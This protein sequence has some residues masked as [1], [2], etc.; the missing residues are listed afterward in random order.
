[1]TAASARKAP[2]RKP[3]PEPLLRWRELR[4]AAG[5]GVL[6]LAAAVLSRPGAAPRPQPATAFAAIQVPQADRARIDSW[7]K[8]FACYDLTSPQGVM[9]ATLRS[10]DFAHHPKW[11]ADAV[12]QVPLAPP[13]T[14]PTPAE[15]A[16]VLEAAKL[17][18]QRAV[19]GVDPC[20]GAGKPETAAP[21]PNRHAGKAG[22]GDRGRREKATFA[23]RF[24]IFGLRS[25][26]SGRPKTGTTPR[27][28]E[29]R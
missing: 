5:L 2:A 18:Q 8:F 10:A 29:G 12:I 11:R 26:F 21:V 16:V 23:G 9:V 27:R 19:P 20:A 15:A 7:P 22:A 6:V 13:A 4:L 28:E 1:M 24:R 25:L 3:P 14:A 17:A